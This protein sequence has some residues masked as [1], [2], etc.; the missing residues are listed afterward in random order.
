M[1]QRL[2]EVSALD[3]LS[4]ALLFATLQKSPSFCEVNPR[5]DRGSSKT[6]KW[7]FASRSSP[8]SA[9]VLAV[10]GSHPPG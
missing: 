9:S 10:K 1:S 6:R 8:I 3:N 5:L 7:I 2:E 4:A